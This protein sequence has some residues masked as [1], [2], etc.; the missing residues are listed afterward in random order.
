M[1][2]TG[3][4]VGL[5]RTAWKPI[6]TASVTLNHQI[7]GLAALRHMLGIYS[8]A[9][10][11]LGTG[12]GSKPTC[13]PAQLGCFNVA[14]LVPQTVQRAD[15]PE[16]IARCIGAPPDNQRHNCHRSVVLAAFAPNPTP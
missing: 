4:M 5:F 13:S 16:H 15:R 10:A 14:P 8:V 2:R 1:P 3:V 11:T 7:A 12:N 6:G 9:S